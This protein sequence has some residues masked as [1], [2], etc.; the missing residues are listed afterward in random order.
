[1]ATCSR[2]RTAAP[3]SDAGLTFNLPVVER[4]LAL[5]GSVDRYADPGFIDYDY[6]LRTPGVSG[7]EPDLSDPEAVAAN[8]PLAAGREYRGHAVRAALPVVEPEAEPV[9]ALAYQLQ[10]QRVGA[11]QV[12]HARSFDTGRHVSAHRYLEPNDRK[13]EL[14]SLELTWA[15]GRRGSAPS[16]PTRGRIHAKSGSTGR[17]AWFLPATGRGAGSEGYRIGGGNNYR[18]CT[19]EEVGLLTDADPAN[20]PPQSGCIYADQALIR[21]DATTNYEVGVRRSWDN[22]RLTFSGTLFHVDWT[23][24]DWSDRPAT[25]GCWSPASGARRRRPRTR[26][27]P[28]C[29][30]PSRASARGW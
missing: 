7:P 20:D 17:P 29:W 9:R 28:R 11:R 22:E 25:R 6:L 19:A 23:D 3:G 18:V 12:N 24:G 1:M 26:V 5:R 2:W 8:L 16:P 14:L 15:P 13:N 27:D 4:K 21:P 10:D 30:R